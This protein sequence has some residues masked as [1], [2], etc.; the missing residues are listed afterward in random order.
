MRIILAYLFILFPIIVCAKEPGNLETYK[1]ALKVYHDSGQYEK[2]ISLVLR[3][4]LSFL[5]TR[6][7]HLPDP[8][9][10][11]AII[12]D[13][14]ETSLSNYESLVKLDFG[15]TE[16]QVISEENQANARV[17][18]PTLKLY[19]FAKNHHIAV[20]FITGRSKNQYQATIENLKKAGFSGWDGIIFKP[21]EYKN[22][23]VAIYKSTARKQLEDKGYKIILNIGDQ[24]SD[25]AGGYAEKSFKVPD[26]YYFIP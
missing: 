13:I 8:G 4:A 10:K 1:Q 22:K 3:D 26:P 15:G 9:K 16:E 5:K 24:T 17:I 6:V 20:F 14:D 19:Q 25:L 21:N 7:A 2:D 12:L 18:T 11:P 23:T